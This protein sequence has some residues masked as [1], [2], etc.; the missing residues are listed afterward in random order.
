MDTHVSFSSFSNESYIHLIAQHRQVRYRD[1]I[2]MKA[3]NF[4]SLV[5]NVGGYMGLFLGYALIQ[6]PKLFL[7]LLHF[8]NYYIFTQYH[9]V[10]AMILKRKS[11]KIGTSDRVVKG[12]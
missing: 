9:L 11:S 7:Q 3:Y 5:G 1:T 10:K 2:Q 8:L 4:D 6:F 12:M